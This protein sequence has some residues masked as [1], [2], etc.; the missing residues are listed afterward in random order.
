MP[1]Y[2]PAV[3]T[4]LT[5]L[6]AFY[7]KPAFYKLAELGGDG[8]EQSFESA[9]SNVAHAFLREKAPALLDYEIGFSCLDRSEDNRKAVGVFG[10]KVGSQWLFAPVFFINGD[11]KGHEL[12]Y[13]K[14][15]DLFVPLKESW[16][17]YLLNRKP[18]L[19]GSGVPRTTRTTSTPDLGYILRR[20]YKRASAHQT[21]EDAC[22]ELFDRVAELVTQ[23]TG[24]LLEKLGQDLNLADFLKQASLDVLE[25]VVN[26]CREMPVV[27]SMLDECHGLHVVAEAIKTANARYVA[28][29]SVLADA[30]SPEVRYG[31][32]LDPDPQLLHPIKTGELKVISPSF[33]EDTTLPSDLSQDDREKL[34]VDAILIKDQ[35]DSHRTTVPYAVQT[36]KVFFNPAETGIYDVLTDAHEFERCLVVRNP[37]GDVSGASFVTVVRLSEPRN[38]RNVSAR[39]VWAVH[40]YDEDWQDWFDKL[41]DGSKPKQNRRNRYMLIGPNREATLPFKVTDKSGDYAGSSVYQAEF[42]DWCDYPPEDVPT[43]RT[44]E[45]GSRFGDVRIHI[46]AVDGTALRGSRG[47]VYVPKSFKLLSLK[48]EAAADDDEYGCCASGGSETPPIRLGELLDVELELL[49]KT[50]AFE[51]RSDGYRVIINGGDRL[52]PQDSLLELVVKHGFTE[53][54]ARGIIKKAQESRKFE[55]RV[56]YPDYI[57]QADLL[58][59]AMTSVPAPPEPQMTSLPAMGRNLP[60][61]L[62]SETLTGI[63]SMR[64]QNTGVGT[65]DPMQAL[66]PDER[67]MLGKAVQTGQKEIFDTSMIG[68]MLRSVRDDAMIGRYLAPLTS[69]LNA[70]GKLLFAFYWHGDKFADKYGKAEM[71]ELEDA[72]RNTFESTGEI[73]LK[74]KT[75]EITAF[76][77][78]G[79]TDIDLGDA[80]T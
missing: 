19:L 53:P 5:K 44:V 57:K 16:L 32:V 4:G 48:P 66:T 61:Q 1:N 31:S 39:S 33:T 71:P 68:S 23:P 56:I 43:L 50:A 40:K 25:R 37:R 63:P 69:G 51:A 21:W 29:N 64:P 55:C 15:Q 11:L 22:E 62:P 52:T 78:E 28:S 73:L 65:Y 45:R 38:W 60:T 34:R 13:L 79:G 12:L 70:L 74:L 76:P 47:D 80:A 18:T 49:R 46:D 42:D 59:P 77:E 58:S 3:H 26:I 9:F 24:Q 7:D 14:D 41:P 72:L 54:V 36:K 20:P 8:N 10:F 27:A 75:K 67:Y 17:N 30:A 35:R 2:S 6:A